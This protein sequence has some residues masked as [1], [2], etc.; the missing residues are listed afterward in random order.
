M[1]AVRMGK[2]TGE[3]GRR[4]QGDYTQGGGDEDAQ[5]DHRC[6]GQRQY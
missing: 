3:V 4:L 6:D 5:N 2:W 1:I